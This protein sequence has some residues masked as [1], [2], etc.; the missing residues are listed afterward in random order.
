[1]S[2]QQKGNREAKKPKKQSDGTKKQKQD[3]NRHDG[4]VTRIVKSSNEQRN[5]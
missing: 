5:I 2:K 4:L 1:M 3:P